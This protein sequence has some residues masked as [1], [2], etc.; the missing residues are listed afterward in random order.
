M[1]K[2]KL[3]DYSATNAS[4][5]DVGGVNIDEGMLP[6]A[7]N[8]A[9][10]EQMTHLKDFADGTTGIDVLNLQDDDASASIKFQAPAA[11]TTTTTFTLPDGDGDSGQTL[12]TNGSGTLAWAAPY[13]NRNLIINGAMQVAQRGTSETGVTS[14][15]YK[16]APDRW[17]IYMS[18][19]GTWTV[20][21]SSTAPDGFSQSYKFDCTTADASLSAGDYARLTQNI[22]GNNLSS[23]KKGTSSAQS[24]TLSFWVRSAKTGTYICEIEDDDNGRHISQA[25]TISVADTWEHKSLTFAGDTSG[26]LTIDNSRALQINWW[27]A[28]GTTYTSGT[29]ATAWASDTNANRAVGQ[30]NLADSTSNDWYMTGVQLEVGE[31]ATPFEHRSFGDELA[32]CQRYY[33]KFLEGGTKEIGVGWYYT[34]THLSFMFRYPTTMRATPTATDTTGTNYYIVYRNGGSDAFNS[35]SFENGSTEQFSAYNN[36]EISG[37]AGQAGIVRSNNAS[38]KIEFD[39]EL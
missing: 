32:R 27:L 11:V 15:G 6:S 18:S 2:D 25:Y 7:V 10:R 34:A 35:V 36:T 16:Q 4:N 23:L 12:I 31:Q 37:T 13:G 5:T 9:I 30:V 33:F 17:R 1:P 24:L 38:A 22:E 3:T 14:G 26:A 28:A 29:L 21:Q 39:A 19:A 8:N 20:S